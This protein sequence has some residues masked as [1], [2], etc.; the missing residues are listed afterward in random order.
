MTLPLAGGSTFPPM[1]AK[2]A[3]P[4]GKDFENFM[5]RLCGRHRYSAS[6][7]LLELRCTAGDRLCHSRQSSATAATASPHTDERPADVSPKFPLVTKLV[8]G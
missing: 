4:R 6:A 7:A 2:V 1:Q 8:D 5:K 3:N